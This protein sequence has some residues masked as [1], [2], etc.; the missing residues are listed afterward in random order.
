MT[1]TQGQ[2]VAAVAIVVGLF[3]SGVDVAAV[4]FFQDIQACIFRIIGRDRSEL[5]SE[6]RE[7]EIETLK[8]ICSMLLA[9]YRNLVNQVIIQGLTLMLV[10]TCAVFHSG[11]HHAFL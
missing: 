10:W 3:P 2:H 11:R 5:T 6:A 7:T 1:H 9:F 8:G 4:F